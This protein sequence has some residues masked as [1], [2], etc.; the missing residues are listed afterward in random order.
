MN[1][2]K[3]Y[4]LEELSKLPQITPP[5]KGKGADLSLNEVLVVLPNGLALIH[6]WEG[7][8]RRIFSRELTGTDKYVDVTPDHPAIAKM[9]AATLDTQ[10]FMEDVV[11]TMEPERQVKLAEMLNL[12]LK[13]TGQNEERKKPVELKTKQ[14]NRC[15]HLQ[16][17]ASGRKLTINLRG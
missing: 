16:V 14:D 8:T 7:H 17:A 11:K 6:D 10:M 9:L 1:P 2:R 12:F 15:A 5:V 4:T 13:E 3:E